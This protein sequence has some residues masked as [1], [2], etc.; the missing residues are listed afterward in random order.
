[1]SL[2]LACDPKEGNSRAYAFLRNLCRCAFAVTNRGS[3]KQHRPLGD[4]QLGAAPVPPQ[5]AESDGALDTGAELLL[6][7]SHAAIVIPSAPRRS[8]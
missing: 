5:P 2:H 1:M 4:F 7:E 6:D 8:A 3:G